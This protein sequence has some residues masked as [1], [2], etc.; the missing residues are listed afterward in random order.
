M[1]FKILT[2]GLTVIVSAIAV[3]VGIRTIVPI[4][5]GGIGILGSSNC[6][7]QQSQEGSN[8]N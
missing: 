8:K 7:G 5:Q 3:G 2:K 6:T 4:S 1:E